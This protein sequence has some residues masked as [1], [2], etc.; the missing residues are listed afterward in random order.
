MP[1]TETTQP[2]ISSQPQQDL[3]TRLSFLQ[4]SP[5]DEANLKELSGILAPHI[6]NLVAEFYQ[7]LQ[8][9]EGTALLLT[10]ELITER[11][12]AAQRA[13]LER[14][15]Q[16]NYDLQY[17][18][19]RLKIG[20][21]HNRI[22]LLP[23][24]YISAYNLYIHL[25]YPLVFQAYRD[26]PERIQ[27]TILSLTKVLMLDMQ[28]AIE[29]YIDSFSK[30]L[31]DANRRLEEYN[32]NLQAMVRQRTEELESFV[33]T[34]SHDLKAPL[35][36]IQGFATAMEEDYAAQF[37]ATAIEYLNYIQRN[38]LKMGDLIQDLLE[39]S[40]I[41]RIENPHEAVEM[42]Q[43]VQ[44]ALTQIQP[45]IEAAH[46]DV[47]I[48]AALPSVQ[49]GK[50]RLVQVFVNL[51]TNAVK[52][53]GEN[54]APRIQIGWQDG[55]DFYEFFVADNGIGI[56]P[57]YHEKI[58]ELFQTLRELEGVE[59]TGVGLAI[60]KRIIEYHQ[61]KVGVTSEKGKGSTFH[62]TLP[63]M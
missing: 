10:D 42:P 2:E 47:Q 39:L 32:L 17:A 58:F 44:E 55:G 20:Q 14:L 63:K 9:F 46:V 52:Y 7:H 27:D 5:Q 38:A 41:G 13:Y 23:R 56:E 49:C 53:M 18:A 43:I 24:W 15:T 28:L 35:V 3:Q 51:L 8:K 30:Q 12:L 61:G 45:Q 21:V 6:S 1:S 31:Q 59:G 54:P 37:D 48:Q 16:G 33:Y 25:L 40:R 22:G 26:D 57:Q 62:F 19:E 34:V 11:L 50:S 36:T 29:A 4:F 60:V